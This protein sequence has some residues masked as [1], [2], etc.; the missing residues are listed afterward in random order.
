[1]TGAY[2]M[3]F[4]IYAVCIFICLIVGLVLLR[5]KGKQAA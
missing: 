5:G 3:A 4:I 2:S 1:M